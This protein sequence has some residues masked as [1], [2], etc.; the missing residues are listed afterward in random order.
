MNESYY[1]NQNITNNIDTQ[2][3]FIS[4]KKNSFKPVNKVT[5]RPLQVGFKSIKINKGSYGI[6]EVPQKEEDID[7]LQK[8]HF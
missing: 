3:Y 7:H 4:Q 2:N 5:N 6:E 8:F 1:T